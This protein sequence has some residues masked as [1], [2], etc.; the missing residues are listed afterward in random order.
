ML[1]SSV[2]DTDQLQKTHGSL[3]EMEEKVSSL[4]KVFVKYATTWKHKQEELKEHETLIEGLVK[5]IE[6]SKA[7]MGTLAKSV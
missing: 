1:R 6:E 3:K 4:S 5:S 7:S 2:V